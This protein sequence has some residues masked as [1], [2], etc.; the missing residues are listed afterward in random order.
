MFKTS[1]IKI[2]AVYLLG[3]KHVTFVPLYYAFFF[4]PNHTGV[5]YNN[6]SHFMSQRKLQFRESRLQKK[7]YHVF[8]HKFEQNLMKKKK[9]AR[10]YHIP[11]KKNI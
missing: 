2:T 3:K 7:M 5:V 4:L 1:I 6:D 11:P 8:I 9:A 10:F